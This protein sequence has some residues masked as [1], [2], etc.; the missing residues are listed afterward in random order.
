MDLCIIKELTEF[1]FENRGLRGEENGKNLKKGKKTKK[2]KQEVEVWIKTK[3]KQ[4]KKQT[5]KKQKMKNRLP[6]PFLTFVTEFVVV[7]TFQGSP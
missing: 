2:K 7:C 3:R 1:C 4:N 6:A 5:K